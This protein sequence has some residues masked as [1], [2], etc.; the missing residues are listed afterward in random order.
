M[1]ILLF[2][3]HFAAST[4]SSIIQLQNGEFFS[5][6]RCYTMQ[7]AMCIVDKPAKSYSL[8]SKEHCCFACKQLGWKWFN[9]IG[10]EDTDKC[11]VGDCQLFASAPQN[12]SQ[13]VHCSMYKV[14]QHN[15][16]PSVFTFLQ[17]IRLLELSVRHCFSMICRIS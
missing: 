13:M 5:R 12:I 9:F 15:R 3:L 4:D 10:D 17:A 8:V 6:V 2:L 11:I 1:M 7:K 16:L 14:S